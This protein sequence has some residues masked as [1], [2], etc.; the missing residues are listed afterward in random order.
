MLR[1]TL[2]VTFLLACGHS[3]DHEIFKDC[4]RIEFCSKL[5]S[6]APEAKYVVDSASIDT[7]SSQ[8]QIILVPNDG[9]ANLNLI[10]TIL[11]E[12]VLRI[13][14]KEVGSE[15]YELQNVLSKEPTSINF[16][17]DD[18]NAE[19][20]RLISGDVEVKVK[21]SPFD[22]ECY[23]QAE[24][25]YEITNQN[26]SEAYVIVES[27]SLDTFVLLGPKP[28]DTVRQYVG[29]TG[30][31]HLP[32]LWTLGYHQ[33]RWNYNSQ[34]DVKDVVANFTKYNFPLDVIWLDIEYTDGKKYFTWDP[35]TFSD[36][37]EMQQNISATN[38][39]L[40]T[41]IDPH[42]KVEEGYGVYEGAL[43]KNLFIRTSNGSNFQGNCWPGLSSY[44]DFLNPEARSYY[45][46]LHTY[47][48]F[49]GSTPVLSG[50]WN[51]MNEPSVF[52]DNLEKTCP[53]DLVH[54][55]GVIHRDIH[56]IYG[57]LHTMS[58]HQGLLDRDNGTKRPFI[59]T[60]SHFAGTQRYSAIWTGDNTAD[61]GYIS[62]SYS[63]CL[64]ANILGIVFCGADVGGFFN[65]PDTELL[66]RWYQ[67]G[68]WLPFYRAHA[69]KGTKRREPYL[70]D[71]DVQAVI[72]NA[73]Q[74]RY[75]HIPVWYT[76]FYEHTRTRDPIIRP[77][78]YHYPEDVNI[79]KISDHLLVGRD[80]LVRAVAEP[81]VES[82][83]VYFPGGSE[84]NW[85]SI[86]SSEVFE[87]NGFVDV[88]VD[89]QA[90]G[91]RL[92]NY[93]RGS[94]IVRKDT[95]RLSSDEMADDGHTIYVN[96][97]ADGKATGTA[98]VDDNTSFDYLNNKKYYYVRIDVDG[99]AI[100]LTEIDEDAVSDD[101]TFVVDQIVVNRVEKSPQDGFHSAS[102]SSFRF[103]PILTH[104]NRSTL[105][106]RAPVDKYV[107]EPPTFDFPNATNEVEM[108]L[109][110][111]DGSS[112]LTLTIYALE[113]R[114]I[115]LK[116]REVDSSRYELQD[117]LDEE[118]VTIPFDLKGSTFTHA[119]LVTGDI[120]VYVNYTPF[121]IE[122]YNKD[123]LEV[124]LHGDRFTFESSLGQVFAFGVSF[125]QA[126][127]LYGIHEHAE[128]FALDNT[129]AGG[130]DPYRLRNLDVAGYEL[131]SPMALY[132]SVPVLYGH[133]P[134]ATAGIFIHNAA[135][136]WY[137][138]SNG[139]NTT[140]AYVM[141]E[142]GSF[143]VFVL[144]GPSPTDVVRQYV[145]LTGT[146]HL[147]QLWTLGYH[148]CRWNYVSQDDLKDVVAN[149]NNYNFPLD[150]IW[151]DIDYTDGKKYFTWDS[152]AFSDPEE[153]QQN[154]S[155]THKRLVTIIDPHIK[156]EQGYNV[157]DGALEKDLFV[158][159]ADGSNFEGDCWP[160][161]SSYMDFL[162][163]AARDYYGSFY[164]Y[165]NFPHST[166]VLAGIWNDMNEPS[167]FDN[168]IEKTIPG[169]AVHYGGVLH[170]D[171]HNIYGL[172]HTMSTHQGLIQRDGGKTRPFVLTRSHFAGTQRY[173]AIWTGD[174]TADW[175]FLSISYE[176]CLNANLL[177]IVFCVIR[178]AIE[179]RYKHLPTWYTLF[180]EHTRNKDP[181]IRPL[182]YHYPADVNVF[183]IS[184]HLLVGRDILVRA[185][186]E[187]GVQSVQVYFPGGSEENWLS[188]GSSEVFEG[189]GFVDVPV[190]IQAIPVYYRRG[191]IIVRKDTVRLSSDEMADDGYT[192][193]INLDA[194]GQAT[195]TAYVDDNTSFDYLNNKK[196]FYIR[197]DMDGDAI[198]VLEIDEDAVSDDFTFII[199]QVVINRVEQLPQN[200]KLLK[201]R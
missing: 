102:K 82:V 169:D 178:S 9:S 160:G 17:A 18:T 7:K 22:I 75:K 12:N 72:R 171:I 125:P 41:I 133:G 124:I 149:F 198:S 103:R 70:F 142:S 141:V 30:T 92:I 100:I 151:L 200:G 32:Q 119:A 168:S 73:I 29:L 4:S 69:T 128:S 8:A 116:I 188:I 25:W 48:K 93:M 184:D 63:Q 152:N 19:F 135:E 181:I 54:H 136:Q 138:I 76:L 39:R 47:E 158:K 139:E 104:Q 150:V 163:P 147:P 182:L 6:R 24:Q 118:P 186:A 180:Y 77:L 179:L 190:D 121:T 145:N 38:K 113:D 140:E 187:P 90:V 159:R 15:R 105:R 65:E 28:V 192:L 126:I 56:N 11:E 35:N 194:Y 122:I 177:G 130:K 10:L 62:V 114:T 196:Y 107:A 21:F 154:I 175:G 33:C 191:S 1:L 173:S 110:S 85:F 95:V 98:Y 112:N 111:N 197:I 91:L 44:L 123:V 49:S 94:I 155:T 2:V 26:Q 16:T 53:S 144:P 134:G 31:A 37:I 14:I 162:N 13:K 27:G 43:E 115:R 195:G 172:L 153:M 78:F 199:D 89:I 52:D 20:L 146:A 129:Q 74:L 170:R 156:V 51:D 132:G 131:N 50:I 193:Y 67:A 84:E 60:R 185:V 46:S 36:P 71:E 79:Y 61:W 42:I 5:R 167:V 3:A 117:V 137:E 143:D 183:K 164:S 40:V 176:E 161:L 101:F 66:Q 189:N 120:R 157:Y 106:T 165:E 99:D 174:N 45:G 80:I 166:P 148:Q 68:V 81:G 96:L 55:G 108:T 64:D 86:G 88:P 57:L 34:E 83:Q 87:G 109:I 201:F 127:Q 97:C 58:T 23:L 59:L